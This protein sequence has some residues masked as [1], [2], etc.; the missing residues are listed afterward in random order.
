VILPQSKQSR[1]RG[2]TRWAD[3]EFDAW[4]RRS[5]VSGQQLFV[6]EAADSDPD[7]NRDEEEIQA[8]SPV[9]RNTMQ[10]E[11]SLADIACLQKRRGRK[12]TY[13]SAGKRQERGRIDGEA[14]ELDDFWLDDFEIESS[15]LE[16]LSNFSDISLYN[17][18]D[19]WEDLGQNEVRQHRPLY[20]AIVRGEDS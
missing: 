12:S 14:F 20:S 19:E 17:D 11:V 8:A 4:K 15:I 3:A 13:E 10:Y 18:D 9:P 2:R 7:W 5:L 1:D 6:D 16:C